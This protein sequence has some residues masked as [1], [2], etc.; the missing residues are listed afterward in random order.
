MFQVYLLKEAEREL[1][2]LP[3][4]VQSKIRGQIK[5]L[6]N[7][8]RVRNCVKIIGHEDTFRLRVGDYRI[9][10]KVY[11]EKNAIVVVGIGH[12]GRVYKRL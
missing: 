1:D 10:F 11:S 6:A 9:L 3:S 7:F 8:P 2:R 4:K 5:T 12:R